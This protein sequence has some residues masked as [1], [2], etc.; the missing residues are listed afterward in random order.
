MVIDLSIY[1]IAFSYEFYYSKEGMELPKNLLFYDAK[2]SAIE[3][4]VYHGYQS[5][6]EE[7]KTFKKDSRQSQVPSSSSL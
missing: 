4:E 2:G 6:D 7:R 3:A 5:D 1:E